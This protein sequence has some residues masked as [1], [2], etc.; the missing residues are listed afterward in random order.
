MAGLGGAVLL[1]H[2]GNFVGTGETM[3]DG[4]GWIGIVAYLFGNYNPIGAAAAA[5]LF[6]GLD[7]LNVQFQTVGIEVSARL[8]NLLPYAAVI[9]VLT[10]EDPDAFVGR[11]A[12]RERGLP[13]FRID[14]F[15][16]LELGVRSVDGPAAEPESDSPRAPNRERQRSAHRHSRDSELSPRS[17]SSPI[18]SRT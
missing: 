2:A 5:L 13:F 6:G 9:V 11:R 18:S 4:R 7:M 16:P 10:A 1:A 3:V 17:E 14:S 8:V 15:C 12:V